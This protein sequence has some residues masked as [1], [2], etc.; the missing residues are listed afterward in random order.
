MHL[1]VQHVHLLCKLSPGSTVLAIS[2]LATITLRRRGLA[3]VQL[4]VNFSSGSTVLA[5]SNLAIIMLTKRELAS[6]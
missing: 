1:Y 5:M 2:D 6:R 4:Y 3:K